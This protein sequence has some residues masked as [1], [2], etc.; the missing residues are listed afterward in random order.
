MC[1]AFVG[2]QPL[3]ST[4]NSQRLRIEESIIFGIDSQPYWLANSELPHS[5][6]HFY[7]LIH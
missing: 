6:K 7:L 3:E 1:A 5:S 4:L 2:F